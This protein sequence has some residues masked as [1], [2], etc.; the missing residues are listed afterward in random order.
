MNENY[1]TI[2]INFD[3]TFLASVT[4]IH[5]AHVVNIIEIAQCIL[6]LNNN[7]LRDN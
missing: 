4:H 6:V 7:Q 2:N 1:G 5:Y 3:C